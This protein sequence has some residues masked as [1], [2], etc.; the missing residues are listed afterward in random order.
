MFSTTD[1]V[2]ASGQT[3]NASSI[4]GDVNI[5]YKISKDG[6][7]RAKAFSRND[8]NSDLLKRGNSQVEQ[9]MGVFYRVEFDTF[10][11][12]FR[13]VFLPKKQEKSLPKAELPADTT[14]SS[15]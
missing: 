2:P 3:Q 9:G 12:F 14:N 8:V 7:F 6:R 1:A 10:G 11:E 5:E 4:T 13:K 15:K